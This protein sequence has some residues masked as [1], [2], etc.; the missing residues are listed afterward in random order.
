MDLT[1]DS[2]I[3]ELVLAIGEIIVESNG[4]ITTVELE[5]PDQSFFLEITVKPKEEVQDDTKI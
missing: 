4:K 2:N 5:I 1:L 3:R